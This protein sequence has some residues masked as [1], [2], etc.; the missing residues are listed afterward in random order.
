MTSE[1]DRDLHRSIEP[2]VSLVV[3]GIFALGSVAI[4]IFQLSSQPN[5]WLAPNAWLWAVSAAMAL[6]AGIVYLQPVR[7][8]GNPDGNTLSFRPKP[9]EPTSHAYSL[10]ESIRFYDRVADIYDARLTRQ[11]LDTLRTSADLLLEAFPDRSR[12]LSVLDVGAGTGQ[13]IRLLEGA[14]RV[15]WTCLEPASGMTT[16]L[17]RFFEGPPVSPTIYEIGLEDAA[18]FVSGRRFEAITMNSM[19]SSLPSLPEFSRLTELLSDDGV[20]LISDGHPDIKSD[21]QTFRVRALDGIHSLQI[22]HRA[23]S[24]IALAVTQTKQFEQVGHER[25]IT[26][27]GRLYSYVLCFRK[28]AKIARNEQ[29]QSLQSDA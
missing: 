20:L 17:R 1:V 18:A 2:A 22:E 25:N 5:A 9:Q 12:Q 23:P 14:K 4:A 8:T 29:K 15:Q 27:A 13:F 16:V 3:S 7:S 19:L 21:A 10:A 28:V 11:Y 26:K 24:E 6:V